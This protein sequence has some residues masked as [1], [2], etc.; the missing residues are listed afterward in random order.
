MVNILICKAREVI[1]LAD[2]DAAYLSSDKIIEW[3]L[4]IYRRIE[5]YRSD[6]YQ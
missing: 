1:S 2:S 3:F 6:R 4:Y 5:P